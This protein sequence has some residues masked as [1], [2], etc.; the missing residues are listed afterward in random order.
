MPGRGR[1]IALLLALLALVLAAGRSG[2]VFLAERLWEASVSEAAALAGARRALL[3]L[4]LEVAGILVGALWCLLHFTAAARVALPDR[5]PPESERVRTW[6]AQ[7]PRWVLPVVAIALG[8]LAGS[9]AGAWRDEVLLALDGAVMGVTDPLLGEDLGRFLGAIPLRFHLQGMVLRL[10]VLALGGVL[11]LH[12]AGGTIRLV[13]RKL[14]ISPRARGHLALLLALLALTLAWDRA[15]EPYRLAAGDRGPLLPSAFLLRRSVTA[16]QTGLGA[17]AAVVTFLWWIRMRGVVAAAIWGVFGL[18][19]LA[20][21]LVPLRAS[22]A[23]ADPDWR[24]S[25]RH[26]DS[27]SY[28]LFGLDDRT[29]RAEPIDIAAP[30]LWDEAVLPAALGVDS[31]A[32]QGTGRSLL[33]LPSG[34]AVPVWMVIRTEPSR[35]P[36]LLA[37]DDTQVSPAGGPLFWRAGDSLPVPGD[38]AFDE[39][40]PH[41][42]RPGAP[43]LDIG[44]EARGVPI[45]S[46]ARRLVLA[47][48]LQAPAAFRAPE[49]SQAGWR[50]EPVSRLRAIAPF[51]HWEPARARFLDGEL[52]WE[53]V[54][55]LSAERFPASTRVPW[56]GARAGL[57]RP[58]LIGLVFAERGRVRIIQRD[59]ADSLAA[60]R[61]R[62]AAPLIEPPGGMPPRWRSRLGPSMTVAAVHGR[63]LEGPA[64]AVGRLPGPG[65]SL[66]EPLPAAGGLGTVLPFLLPQVCETGAL[67][68]TEAFA[69]RDLPRLVRIDS[70]QAIECPA[71]LRQRWDRFPFRHSLADSVH[72]AEG[73]FR[74][75]QVRYA[76]VAEGFAAYQ[77]A[78]AVP[79]DG[80]ASLVM[81]NVALGKRLGTGRTIG[82]AWRNLRGEVSPTA[83]G[84]SGQQ[85]LDS[86]R[87]WMRRADSALRRGDLRDLGIALQYLRELLDPRGRAP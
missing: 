19:V 81:V 42:I 77:P 57:V 12:V 68:L 49:G 17:G 28:G 79:P 7:F 71:T 4:A 14:W 5:A 32:V 52:V 29:G 26:M 25:A 30:A 60:A 75:G 41:G 6:P 62:V 27:V 46:W 2:S 48:A 43:T 54:G 38:V 23:V 33:E 34:R 86:A 78:Y 80:R 72:A 8:V 22:Q 87:V 69:A 40:P 24:A 45:D 56:Q 58:S 63:V 47:W 83:P 70:T 84:T 20:G 16:V 10:T 65:G 64:W 39:L 76:P 85:I 55:V 15:L 21:R 74:L 37:L 44:P 18:G 9:G 36:E 59:P 73:E 31:G 51:V 82:E 66:P 3:S 61:A 13:E 35:P 67:L 50:L 1:R 11:L 53:S